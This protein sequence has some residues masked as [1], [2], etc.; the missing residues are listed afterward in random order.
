[1]AT[2]AAVDGVLAGCVNNELVWN[3]N[4]MNKKLMIA[5][6]LAVGLPV[7]NTSAEF[8]G[9]YA[10]DVFS[11]GGNVIVAEPGTGPVGIGN[12]NLYSGGKSDV[13]FHKDPQDTTRLA[14]GFSLN[15]SPDSKGNLGSFEILQMPVGDPTPLPDVYTFGYLVGE[16]ILGNKY[17]YIDATGSN[18]MSGSASGVKFYAPRG[19]SQTWGFYV[20]NGNTANRDALLQI[21]DW[22]QVVPEPSSVA[23]A[24]VTGLGA[25]GF[26]VRR[27]RLLKSRKG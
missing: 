25:L 6:G 13:T 20:W 10:I 16:N 24:L 22:Q 11:P 2:S 23:M 1:L 19:G 18:A 17:Y 27:Y 26:S 14:K 8:S 21:Q 9:Y 4:V 7:F 5:V 3:K 15:V 12:W